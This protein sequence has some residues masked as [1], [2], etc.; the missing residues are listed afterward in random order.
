MASS[1]F[2][3]PSLNWSS[4]NLPEAF[5]SFR[6]YS[7]LI[8]DGP[9]ANKTE[10]EK[11]TYL[12]LWI[13]SHG[14]DIYDGWTWN[15]PEEKFRLQIVLERFQRHIEPQVNSYLAR[16]TFHQCRQAA[17]ESVDEFIARCRVIAAKCKFTDLMETNIRLTEQL[18][19]GTKHV[20]VQEKLLEKG[21]ALA[22]LEA[23]MD[24]ARTFEATKAHV[25]Q[26]QATGPLQVHAVASK[27]TSSSRP[28]CSRCG[29]SHGSKWEACPAHG[30]K[31]H[32][33]GRRGHY[34]QFCRTGSSPTS[35]SSRTNAAR[36]PKSYGRK[37]GTSA[38][39]NV[40]SVDAVAED[41]ATL[42]FEVVEISD[43]STENIITAQVQ[44]NLD[45]GRV[46]N[47][48]GKVDTG[49]QGNLL[50][51]RLFRQMFPERVDKTGRPRDGTL[52]PSTVVLKAYGG[53]NIP[54][55]GEC[56]IDC[57]LEDKRCGARFFVTDT[58]GPALF[59]LPLI[60]GLNLLDTQKD[61]DNV[62]STSAKQPLN[63]AAVLA[64]F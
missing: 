22:S 44:F 50:P 30:Q 20:Q 7:T 49:A 55:L 27:R 13:G 40:S 14:R 16:Y 54:H 58:T 4:P 47:L 31:C 18:I 63:K 25:A 37:N 24:I 41:F 53:T 32:A 17:D 8:F 61:I 12:L 60:K 64:E 23:A 38:E 52:K 59:G 3:T 34:A 2:A 10:K 62:T 35:A 39:R 5:R 33:C 21:D 1:G 46:A 36:R 45:D 15:T 43:I 28:P 29:T 48:R 6:Q 56:V 51:I 9:F 19:V 11:V 57:C 42:T 26:L